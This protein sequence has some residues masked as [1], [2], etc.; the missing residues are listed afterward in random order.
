MSVTCQSTAFAPPPQHPGS[1]PFFQ[2]PPLQ[3]ETA[4]ER[5]QKSPGPRKNVVLNSHLSWLL[6]NYEAA[7][8]VSVPRSALYGHYLRHCQGQRAP[9]ATA[10]EPLNAASFGKLLRSVFL[11]I[12]TRRLGT[13]GNSKYHYY[14]IRLKPGSPLSRRLEEE[15]EAEV[16]EEEETKEP[17]QQQHK[18]HPKI[19]AQKPDTEEVAASQSQHH[20]QFIDVTRVL[21]EFPTLGLE[22]LALSNAVQSNEAKTLQILYRRHCE[23]N[24]E[25][26]KS[27]EFAYIETL[28]HSFWNSEALSSDDNNTDSVRLFLPRSRLTAL[29][30]LSPVVSWMQSCDRLLFQTLLETLVPDVL[31]P[32]PGTLTQSIRTFAKGLEGWLASAMTG[33]PQQILQAKLG[34]VSAFGRALRRQTSLNHL[35]QAARAVLQSPSQ[36]GQMLR[37]LNRVDFARVQEQ[38]A[39]VCRWGPQEDEEAAAEED[40]GLVRRL[41]RGFKRALGRQSSLEQWAQWMESALSHAL[42]PHLGKPRLPSA[43]RHFLLQWSFYSSMVIRDLTLRSAASFGSFH[44]LRLLYDEYMFYLVENRLAHHAHQ[45]GDL[46]SV[47]PHHLEEDAPE[48]PVKRERHEDDPEPSLSPLL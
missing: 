46:T 35:A 14:G 21:P 9:T 29:C 34:S 28:W 45:V 3:L 11:G 23:A 2:P 12:R 37:D 27:L 43:A 10:M 38:A 30:G 47:S 16:E 39:W 42:R 31:R 8:G 32:V 1:A 13:R 48:P 36:T 24:V 6:E 18:Q 15:E 17:Q 33:F 20:Q 25:V 41:E 7:E 4:T 26:V 5:L 22:G 44:L 40:A 19:I